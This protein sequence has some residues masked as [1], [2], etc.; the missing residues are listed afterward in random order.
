MSRFTEK[1]Y[2]NART[3]KTGMVTGEPHEPVRHTW[4][5][6]H[7]RARRIAGGLKKAG[8]GLGDAVGVLAGFPVEIAPTAQGLWMRGASLTML[9]QPTPRTDL[10]V[11]AEDTMNVITMIEAKAV[12]VSDPFLP[13]IPVLEEKGVQV[14]KV[15]ELL[16]SDP[17]DP[18]DVG[19]DDLALMQLTSGSTGSPKAVQ[20]THR[21]IYSNAEAMF[22]GAQYD[23]EKDVMVSWLPCFHD[24]GMVGFLTIPM[25]FGAEL[26]K[27]TPMDFLRDTLLWAKLIH[28]YKGTMTAAP[29]FAYALLAKR[30]RRQAKPGDFD[31]STLRFALSG[32]E[33][34]EPADVE[35]LLDAGKPFG[36]KP[37]A[38][39]PA[40]GM[41]E[42]TLAV[43]FSPC[44]KGLV[45]DEVDADL[46]AALRRA[47]P[48]TKGNTKRLASL[49]P[50]LQDL[51]AR[52]IDEH[53]SVM[54]PRGVGVIEL[55]GECVTPG[56]MT[57]G[58]FIPA[59][60]EHGWYDT[61]DLGY[62][63]EEGNIVVCGR[64]K[65]V[66]IMAGRNIYPTDIERA[67]C[68][69]EG[70]RPGCAVA[71]RLDAGHSRETFAVAVE[72]NAWQDPDE[73]HRIER[74][75]AHEVVAEVDV[76]PRNVVVLGPGS[77]PKTSSGKL[78]RSNS[79]SLV[80]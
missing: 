77:I 27:V 68:R 1:M 13:A 50:L 32:A 49:G 21:N 58:G 24:M 80:T 29:N 72:S 3:A 7:E 45:V 17:T 33:P 74:Q 62:I 56:Y 37:E 59:Q 10:M 47:V 20:I 30:L 69:V 54:P 67:A 43:S 39:L 41:A 71:V 64:V 63:T 79:V 70:V 78:R 23:V 76:R 40:Y 44:G 51:E 75:V 25:Y 22:V 57:M 38:I 55:R 52:V 31:L 61:G 60:D 35:D 42:T 36:L 28:K 19:E 18:I 5:E 73:V 6:V 15:G 8:I 9:H 12:I 16:E 48:A 26:V 4:L 34:V 2:Y 65:D 66:I 14:L 11:W 46:L 53:G